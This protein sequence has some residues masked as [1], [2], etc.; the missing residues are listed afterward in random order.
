MEKLISYPLSAIYYLLHETTLIAFQAVQWLCLNLFGYKAHKKSADAMFFF[1]V[2]NTY[3]L[4]T[5][6]KIENRHKLPADAPLIIVANHQSMYDFTTIGW[7]FRKMYPKFI[8]KI[9]LRK[10]WAG[11]SYFLNHGGGELI[12][13]KNPTQSLP[14]L[15]KVAQYIEVNKLPVVIFPEGTR[16]NTTSKTKPFKEKGL[17]ILCEFAPSAYVIP[18]TINNSWKMTK[19]GSFPLG[20]GNKIIFT[21]HDSIPVKKYSLQEVFEKTEQ[22]IIK[23]II[24]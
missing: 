4:G 1:L 22:T 7:F 3:I 12:D 15:K 11:I 10:G 14:A 24:P 18:V 19:W 21:I 16:S 20:L 23:A 2:F 8:G 9:E 13:R 6:Y 17:K 5:R